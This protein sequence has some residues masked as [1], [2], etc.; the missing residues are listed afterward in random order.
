VD[1]NVLR[2]ERPTGA[3]LDSKIT[4]APSVV[5]WPRRVSPRRLG[6]A[7]FLAGAV[8]GVVALGLADG[9]VAAALGLC[10]VGAAALGYAR[11]QFLAPLVA[12]ALP[13]G[14]RLEV[15][16]EH[17]SALEAIV[18]GGALGYL[19][20]LV[21]TPQARRFE[22]AHG[23]LAAFVL[24][25]GIST[26]GPIDDSEQIRTFLY[27][28]ALGLVFHAAT[29]YLRRRD[30]VRVLLVCIAV[31]TFVEAALTLRDYVSSWSDRFFALGGA[32]VYPLPTGTMPHVNVLAMFLVL[33]VL[34]LIALAQ[35]ERGA[36]RLTSLAVA[37][38]GSLAL[39]VTFSRTAWIAFV[40]GAAVYLLERRTRVPVLVLGAVAGGVFLVLGLTHHGA[41]GARIV[42]LFE[43]P[44][45]GLSDFRLEILKKGVDVALANPLTGG[46]HFRLVGE[47]A[48]RLDVAKHPHNLFLGIAVFF[49]IPAAIAFGTLVVLAVRSALSARRRCIGPDRVR[50]TG[51]VALMVAFLVNGLLEYPFWDVTLSALI[52]LSLATVIALDP[53]SRREFVLARRR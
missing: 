15:L 42:S 4:A 10:A 28:G 37:A 16:G 50:A 22:L 41:I 18:G 39:L 19:A 14:Y 17:F 24:L 30:L 31:A 51:L 45:N 21:A 38:A 53:A 7:A 6:W 27:W 33:A 34:L 46:G 3:P 52:V 35:A 48:D 43:A 40:A 36:L 26:V 32:I 8:V 20:Y 2:Y 13:G 9:L 49:G 25:I 44:T 11:P 47:Y 12:L 1:E 23:A 5:V 29:T